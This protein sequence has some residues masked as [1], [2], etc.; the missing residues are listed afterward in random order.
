MLTGEWH[1]YCNRICCISEWVI[2]FET[3]SLVNDLGISYY[4]TLLKVDKPQLI[5]IVIRKDFSYYS[6]TS[7]N[8]F[9][10]LKKTYKV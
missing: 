6:I 9:I 5:M 1:C 4:L 8:K 7:T 2:R 3:S 10:A